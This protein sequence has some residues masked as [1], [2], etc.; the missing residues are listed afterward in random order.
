MLATVVALLAVVSMAE[1]RA[2][3]A[4]LVSTAN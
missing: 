4:P 2:D 3:V 1:H